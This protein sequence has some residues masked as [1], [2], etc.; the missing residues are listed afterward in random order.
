MKF[1]VDSSLL[2]SLAKINEL[3]NKAL[4]SWLPNLDCLVFKEN[5]K[6][7][8]SELREL[9][10]DPYFAEWLEKVAATPLIFDST[11][12][13][14]KKKPNTYSWFYKILSSSIKQLMLQMEQYAIAA[15]IRFN[16]Y[17]QSLST[18]ITLLYGLCSSSISIAFDT[19]ESSSST[20]I[21]SI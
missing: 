6:F 17:L 13:R 21:P 14:H 16:H 18:S 3:Y 7:D 12:K 2:L 10:V 1:I 19:I 9:T 20:R 8:F 5:I 15:I 11:L 4:E